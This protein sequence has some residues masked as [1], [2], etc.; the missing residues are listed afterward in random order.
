M[1]LKILSDEEQALICHDAY[2][3]SR[4]DSKSVIQAEE[5]EHKALL[6][7]QAKLTAEQSVNIVDN[8]LD[9]MGLGE[10]NF[11]KSAW[12]NWQALKELARR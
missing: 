4:S 8:L 11:P 7:A 10:D 9:S 12:Q 6:K 1:E 2:F 5:A 3:T